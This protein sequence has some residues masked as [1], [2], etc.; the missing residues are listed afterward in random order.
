MVRDGGLSAMA[1][2]PGHAPALEVGRT[3]ETCVKTIDSCGWFDRIALVLLSVGGECHRQQQDSGH[4]RD[5]PRLLLATLSANWRYA[6]FRGL[7]GAADARKVAARRFFRLER[8][9]H[10][11]L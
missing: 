9:G 6:G 3:L 8:A 5:P 7:F 10:R 11:P 2:R 1:Y 4:D